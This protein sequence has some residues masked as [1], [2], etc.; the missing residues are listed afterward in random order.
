MDKST[1]KV[2]AVCLNPD[3]GIPKLPVESVKLVPELGLER[4]Y[5]SGKFV[6]HRYLQKK[7]PDRLNNRQVLLIDTA[8]L[9]RLEQEDIQ[10]SPGQMGENM[11]LEGTDLMSLELGTRLSIGETLLELTEVRDPCAQ[12][13]ASHPD[14]FAATLKEIDGELVYNAG[15]FASILKGGTV[16]AG[17]PVQL[18]E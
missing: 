2:L 5:H 7:D 9:A 14:L 10:L 18:E 12:L 17:D 6:R 15:M 1:A 3:P 8:L 4:D 11:V 16:Q 13:N